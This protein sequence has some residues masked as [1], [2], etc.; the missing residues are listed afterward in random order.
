MKE[1]FDKFIQANSPDGGFLQSE[2]WRKFQGSY[3]Q[4][5]F[6]ISG[7]NFW[8]NIIEH[9]LKIVGKY[10]Y[11]PRGPIGTSG[12]E[13][14]LKL[15]K[16]NGAGWVRIEPASQD[17]L[18]GIRKS[19]GYRI[20]K[21]PHDMQPK[22]IFVIDIGK[23]E[24]QLLAEMKGKTRY[25]LRLA[26]KKGVSVAVKNNKDGEKEFD[27]FLRLVK[28]TARRNEI[29]AHPEKY[30][31]KMWEVLPAEA[32]K[33]Y[34]AEYDG[35]IIAANFVLFFGRVAIYLHGASDNAFRETM[36]PYLLQWQAIQ[37]AKKEGCTR[38]DFGGVSAD[39]TNKLQG[40]T[41]FKTGFSPETKP[42]EF[43]G[44]YDIIIDRWRYRLYRLVSIVKQ[45]LL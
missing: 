25:N 30:Y 10:F 6:N 21:A 42:I 26:E 19:S 45:I 11:V 41:K 3:G 43:P 22:E 13:A 1:F 33:L 35:K 29:S 39:Q 28:V 44:A 9:R 17:I 5:T 16:E 23:P 12:M 18:D 36:A 4:R 15:A 34:V 24:E 31:R 8:A 38:Y 2:E 20:V 14:I 27:E 37:D 32:L 7:E 40:V